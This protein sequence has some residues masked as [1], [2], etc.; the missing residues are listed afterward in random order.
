MQ[1]RM[2][3]AD[4]VSSMTA[5]KKQSVLYNHKISDLTKLM[6]QRRHLY[7]TDRSGG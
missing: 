1:S 2:G 4:L 7:A 5:P 3:S 6:E